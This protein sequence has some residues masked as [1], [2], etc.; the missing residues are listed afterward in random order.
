M[1]EVSHM[2]SAI[3]DKEMVCAK[4]KVLVLEQF[5]EAIFQ[6]VV[7]QIAA[8]YVEEHYAEIAARLDQNAIATLAVADASKKIA[9]EIQRRPTIIHEKGDT[10]VFQFG[11]LGGMRRVR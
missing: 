11:I 7:R 8:R 1:I 3:D 4:F 9:E 6:E 5:P 10:Q 2:K